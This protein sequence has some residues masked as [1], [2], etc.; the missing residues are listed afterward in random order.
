MG[1]EAVSPS[2]EAQDKQTDETEST[3]TEATEAV[4]EEAAETEGEDSQDAPEDQDAQSGEGDTLSPEE[5]HRINKAVQKRQ[6]RSDRK[7]AKGIEAAAQVKEDLKIAQDRNRLYELALEQQKVTKQEAAAYPN[8]DDFDNGAMDEKFREATRQYHETQTK[9]MVQEEV[10]RAT[11]GI[12][13]AQNEEAK[14]TAFKQR[15]TEHIRSSIALD[16]AD[17][18]ETEDAVI[19]ILGQENVDHVINST[20]DAH[21]VLYYMGKNPHEAEKIRDLIETDPLKAAVHI[22]RLEAAAK[23]SPIAKAKPTPDPDNEIEGGSPSAGKS[24]RYDREEKAALEK[25]E[26][27]GSM[28]DLIALR[29]KKRDA[30]LAK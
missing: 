28:D 8:P 26:V 24:N 14:A 4:T 20:P 7:A 6:K 11:A 1:N 22:G 16:T 29:K 19:E 10:Q 18:D 25:A 27:T 30:G 13:A 17:Y 2:D 15:N 9:A 21:L 12:S 23:G 5:V 3:E